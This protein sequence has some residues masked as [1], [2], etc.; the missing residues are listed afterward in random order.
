MPVGAD[1]S[2]MDCIIHTDFLRAM[3]WPQPADVI[4]RITAGTD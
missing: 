4:R 3:D 2:R 1:F